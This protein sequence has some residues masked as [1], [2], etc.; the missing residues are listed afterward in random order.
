MKT[1]FERLPTLV[2]EKIQSLKEESPYSVA[3]TI[4]DLKSNSWFF[5]LQFR[6]IL[7]IE[8]ACFDNKRQ[9]LEELYKFFECDI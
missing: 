7:I 5:S 4:Q 1:L 3:E 6:T 8:E 9:S 2:I